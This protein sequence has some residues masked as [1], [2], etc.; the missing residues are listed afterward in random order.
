[1]L[2]RMVG[3]ATLN[4]A[5]YEEVEKDKGAT[6]QALLVVV[7]VAISAGVGGVLDGEGDWGRGLAYGA[8]RGVVSW[9]IWALVAWLVGTTILKTQDT[10]ADWGQLARGTGFAQTPGLLNILVFIST[11]GWL[12]VLLTFLWQLAGMVIAVRQSLDYTSTLRAIFV[13]VISLIPVIII[14]AIIFWALGI[15]AE[16]EE[17]MVEGAMS[18]LTIVQTHVFGA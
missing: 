8:I 18:L 15:G 6:I 17:E 3:A 9:A 13:I 12:I 1:M 2:A 4:A 16:P 10:E 7:A 11:W 5:T 14:N